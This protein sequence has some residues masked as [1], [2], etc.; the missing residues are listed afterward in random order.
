MGPKQKGG[1][2]KQK[3]NAAEEV[4]E[5]LQAVV[6]FF[7]IP[8]IQI[9]ADGGYIG[10]CGYFRDPIRAIYARQ[11][12]GMSGKKSFVENKMVDLDD[13]SVFS[14]SPIPL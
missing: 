14:P 4:E 10:S 1:G 11:A 7:G 13:D 12:T 3:G 9:D 8:W 6:C 5:T 2:Q